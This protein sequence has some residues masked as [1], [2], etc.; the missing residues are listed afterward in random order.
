MTFYNLNQPCFVRKK[1]KLFNI[2]RDLL[3]F[4][5]SYDDLQG[6]LYDISFSFHIGCTT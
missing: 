4:A 5:S 6:P 1:L 2:L 3:T